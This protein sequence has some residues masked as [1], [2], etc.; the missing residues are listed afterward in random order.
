ME[1]FSSRCSMSY[2]KVKVHSEFLFRSLSL[3]LLR[4]IERRVYWIWL[5]SH[6]EIH[7]NRQL[8]RIWHCFACKIHHFL[9]SIRSYCLFHAQ[10]S[11][12]QTHKSYISRK[13]WTVVEAEYWVFDLFGSALRFLLLKRKSWFF[14]LL[15]QILKKKNTNQT[16]P[17]KKCQSKYRVVVLFTV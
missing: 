3:S 10:N 12:S 11:S 9:C 17:N 8:S 4:S 7:E 14:P 1:I 16:N 2:L 5:K 15:L 6:L 13:R